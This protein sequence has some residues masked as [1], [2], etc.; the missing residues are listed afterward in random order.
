MEAVYA[1]SR[2]KASRRPQLAST[3]SLLPER[4]EP[5]IDGARPSR[6][7]IGSA[8][9]GYFF[10]HALPMALCAADMPARE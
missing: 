1:D 10:P 3:A 7:R 4:T 6:S 8:F 2:G 9:V 5:V